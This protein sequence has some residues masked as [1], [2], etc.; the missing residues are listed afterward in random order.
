MA[1]KTT[2]RANAASKKMNNAPTQKD[3]GS[4]W[5]VVRDGEQVY[6]GEGVTR[7]WAEHLARGLVVPG[8]LVEVVAE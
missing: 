2:R 6:P 8:E 7:P 5:I 3:D 1:S 4:R